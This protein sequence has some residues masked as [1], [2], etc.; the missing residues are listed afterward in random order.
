MIQDKQPQPVDP[1]MHGIFYTR[2]S[3]LV[4][5]VRHESGPSRCFVL[6][7][8]AFSHQVADEETVIAQNK[9]LHLHIWSG[10]DAA[11]VRALVPCG[12]LIS[13]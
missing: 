8:Y 7:A 4:L 2:D 5:N 12:I 6:C 13:L 11:V 1:K 9:G 3:Y 10:K